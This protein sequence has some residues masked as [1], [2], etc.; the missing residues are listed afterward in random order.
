LNHIL[1]LQIELWRNEKEDGEEHNLTCEASDFA[2][3]LAHIFTA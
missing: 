3:T 2:K 1:L